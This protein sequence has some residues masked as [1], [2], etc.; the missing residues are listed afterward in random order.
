MKYLRLYILLIALC[1]V[2]TFFSF[3]KTPCAK[4]PIRF[5]N[6]SSVAAV[7]VNIENNTFLLQLDTGYSGGIKLN[8]KEMGQIEDKNPSR[9][10]STADIKGN[11]YHT[12][13][14]IIPKIDLES[15]QYED[16][17]LSKEN[18]YF[19]EEGSVVLKLNKKKKMTPKEQ[20]RLGLQV[21][22]KKN[23]YLDLPHEK[24]YLAENFQDFA[25]KHSLPFDD[26]II[27]PFEQEANLIFLW[28]E[29]D[30]GKKRFLLDTGGSHSLLSK[31]LLSTDKI[32][33]KK[34]GWSAYQT[35]QFRIGGHDFG[36]IELFL[37]EIGTD[38]ENFDG[39]L[40]LDF[41]RKHGIFIDFQT[42]KIYIRH[43]NNDSFWRR[44]LHRIHGV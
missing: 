5:V 1:G 30:L 27:L 26:F 37:F 11:L 17:T 42:H 9:V 15:I 39:I 31:S 40:G 13:E 21:L 8:E 38:L 19:L 36:E 44:A 20:G 35:K 43:S 14:F 3:E 22:Q 24:L 12:Q 4:I 29:T 7:F 25:R 32:I 10:V 28:I 6:R 23:L 2:F 34:E 18:S 16:V 41:I 33:E